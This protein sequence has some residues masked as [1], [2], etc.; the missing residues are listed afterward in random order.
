M[1]KYQTAYVMSVPNLQQD[2]VQYWLSL[3][4]FTHDE[5]EAQQN[6]EFISD[7]LQADPGFILGAYPANT[8]N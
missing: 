3:L 2:L 7:F 5:E 8:A 1:I 4:P 6:M